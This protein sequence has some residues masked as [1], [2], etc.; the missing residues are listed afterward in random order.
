MH[1]F[2]DAQIGNRHFRFFYPSESDFREVH[3]DKELGSVFFKSIS[4]VRLETRLAPLMEVLDQIPED[5]PPIH[6]VLSWNLSD[7]AVKVIC[8]AHQVSAHAFEVTMRNIEF[9]Q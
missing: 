7:P 4:S 1:L 8:S 9:L 3:P 5:A 6:L 2:K